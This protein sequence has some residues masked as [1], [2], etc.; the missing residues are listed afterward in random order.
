MRDLTKEAKRCF[1][2]QCIAVREDD[3]RI[4]TCRDF[5][6][7]AAL[8]ETCRRSRENRSGGAFLFH[9][10][11]DGDQERELCFATDRLRLDAQ[12]AMPRLRRRGFAQSTT[13]G[14][15]IDVLRTKARRGFVD[16]DRGRIFGVQKLG[17]AL[18]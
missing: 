17:S 6:D 15:T 14:R 3:R 8:S 5:V 13:S 7:E 2:A 9:L 1:F 10:R 4:E 16:E 18:D 12:E 11:E